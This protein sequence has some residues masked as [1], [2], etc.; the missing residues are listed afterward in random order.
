MRITIR[1][2]D[3]REREFYIDPKKYRSVVEIAEEICAELA[4]EWIAALRGRR[5]RR[6]MAAREAYIEG[7]M[8]WLYPQIVSAIAEKLE[9]MG[10]PLG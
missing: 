3:G 10:Y 1:F 5:R 2:P 6:A 4:D 9:E 8:R 7:C